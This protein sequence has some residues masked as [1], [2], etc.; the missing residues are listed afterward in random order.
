MA[1]QKKPT[2]ELMKHLAES[3]SRVNT[4]DFRSLNLCSLKNMLQYITSLREKG[5]IDEH[6]FA[7]LLVHAYSIFIENALAER[8]QKVLASKMSVFS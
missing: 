7:G 1:I 4:S 8:I 3:S 2:P 5:V 6:D